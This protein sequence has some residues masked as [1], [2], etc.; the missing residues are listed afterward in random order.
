MKRT[1]E[2]TFSAHHMLIQAA[3][4]AK[5]A[6]AKKDP[7]W[8]YHLLATITFSALA[9]EAICNSVGE[10]VVV[11]W[12]DF[13]GSS[14]NAKL[15]LL[16]ERLSVPYS[17]LDEPW[18][19]ARQLVKFRNLIAHAKPEFII[20]ERVMTQDENEKRLFD[21]P[22]SKLETLIT[23]G[24]ADRALQAAEKIKDLFLQEL[25][26]DQKLGLTIDGWSGSTKVYNDT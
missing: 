2:R 9:I 21:Q 15:R 12:Q 1:Q 16:A 6:A 3:A 10:R 14:P 26:P 22:K 19:T 8:F 25:T 13:E 17:K 24:N 18:S 11:D 5:K 23:S 7:G 4:H 20:E